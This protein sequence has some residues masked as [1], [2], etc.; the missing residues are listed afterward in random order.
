MPEGFR[1][2][3]SFN[4]ALRAH[5]LAHPTLEHER[6]LNA[7]RYGRHT[8]NLLRDVDK[9]PMAALEAIFDAGV[10]SYLR[11]LPA[12]AGHPFLARKPTAWQLQ[13]WA[14]V[15]HTQGHQL[16]H[17]HPDGW[18]SGVYYAATPP[19]IRDGDDTHAG[20]IEFGRPLPEL[21]K[22]DAPITR[23]LRPREGMLVLFPSYLYHETV[24]FDSPTHRIS[25]AFDAVPG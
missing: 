9:G 15:M 7:T 2:L 12:D 6:P 5:I 11:D 16:A 22:D 4:A 23:L 1:D 25:I 17:T 8:D 24:A 13:S 10:A 3:H 21:I 19:A 20:W 18:V 14:V